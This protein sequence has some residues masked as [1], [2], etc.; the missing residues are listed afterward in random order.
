[1]GEVHPDTGTGGSR[2][3]CFLVMVADV[4]IV[5][6]AIGYGSP[7]RSATIGSA[8]NTLPPDVLG[9]RTL[10]ATPSAHAKES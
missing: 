10:A 9:E 8:A 5:V 6:S 4:P 3:T 1:L 2:A 7:L